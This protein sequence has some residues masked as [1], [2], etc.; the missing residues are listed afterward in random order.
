M[1]NVGEYKSLLGVLL[2]ISVKSRT[3][4]IFA[5][6]Q[7][8]RNCEN[9]T[10]A[11]YGSL[12]YLLQYLKGTISNSICYNKRSRFIG[13]SDSDFASDEKTRRSTS[14]VYFLTWW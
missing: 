8:S 14:G 12:M 4:I 9:P 13:Y 7:A 3:D 11:D 10:K 2:C 6:N 1:V 5:V